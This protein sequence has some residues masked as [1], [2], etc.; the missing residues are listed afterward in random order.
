[1]GPSSSRPCGRIRIPGEHDRTGLNQV[2]VASLIEERPDEAGLL[3]VHQVAGR[4][5][6]D[7]IVLVSPAPISGR[8]QLQRS[9]CPIKVSAV[10]DA[11]DEVALARSISLG[12]DC[13]QRL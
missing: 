7:D 12:E 8:T 4:R 6:V 1:M 13:D 5:S 3:L 11:F 2:R 9:D 10:H